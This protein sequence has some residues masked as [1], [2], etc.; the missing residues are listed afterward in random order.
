MEPEVSVPKESAGEQNS[1]NKVPV[2]EVETEIGKQVNSTDNKQEEKDNVTVIN[3][4]DSKFKLSA[5]LDPDINDPEMFITDEQ[6]L[7]F[8]AML[9]Q[10]RGEI[11]NKR[12]AFDNWLDSLTRRRMFALSRLRKLGLQHKERLQLYGKVNNYV[13]QVEEGVRSATSSSIRSSKNVSRAASGAT[14]TSET[15]SHVHT[16]M[17]KTNGQTQNANGLPSFIETPTDGVNR[18]GTG[19]V[20]KEMT[21]S[22]ESKSGVKESLVIVQVQS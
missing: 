1:E 20:L 12:Q 8:D 19:F 6:R 15:S 22:T 17:S 21:G 5:D 10:K 11:S 2:E 13:Q 3:S 14:H 16:P 7:E 18:E 9:E 4:S